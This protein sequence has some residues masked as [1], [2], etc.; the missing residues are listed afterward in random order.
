MVFHLL[1]IP[2]TVRITQ[3]NNWYH[4]G[5]GAGPQERGDD[6]NCGAGIPLC[7]EVVRTTG[8]GRQGHVN[9]RCR[10]RRLHLTLPCPT[11][12]QVPACRRLIYS[13]KS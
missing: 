8:S 13:Y 3:H 12:A 4:L 5:S 1:A 9:S 7:R 6:T 2:F 10:R 11:P